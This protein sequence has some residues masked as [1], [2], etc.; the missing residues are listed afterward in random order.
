MNICFERRAERPDS[1]GRCVIRLVATFE[2]QRLRLATK[3]KCLASEWNERTGWFRKSFTDID[4][5]TTRLKDLRDRV[6]TAY[7]DL[8]TKHGAVTVAQLK[9]A[10][11]VEAGA[12]APGLVELL[13]EHRAGLPGRGFR[14]NTV[15]GYKTTRNAVAEWV[16]T[17]PSGMTVPEYNA[18]AHDA[19]IGW[20]R[21]E[22]GHGQNTIAG[23]VKHL[24]PF[25]TW[26][27]ETRAQELAVDPSKLVVEWEDVEKCWLTADELAAVAKA[28]LPSNLALVRD[29]FVFC[30]YTGLRYSDLSDL[31]PGNLADWKGG[32]VLRLT[33]T[34]TRTGVSI[35][36]TKPALALLNNYDGTRAR[37][38][39]VMANAVMNRYLKRI[40]RLAGLE[41]PVELVEIVD[42]RVF[43]R[44]VPK[45]ELVTM[46][47][48]RHTFATQSLMRGM[49]VEVL[50]KV[51]GHANIKTT[52]IYAK[53]VEDFQH[54]TMQRIW[55]G[56]GATMESAGA[57]ESQICAVEPS[58][59]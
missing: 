12:P 32:K 45:W 19:L 49:P 41:Q 55:E 21:E 10:L 56:Q 44:A 33:Q 52:L 1:A 31:H 34:K 43:K 3:E 23:M 22:K 58:A 42:G 24:K 26:A 15:K 25:L 29:A 46:H 20:L 8:R 51:L 57:L 47:T 13:D 11:S 38:M 18:A 17:L 14:A 30:C 59:A 2:N 4:N 53:I 35:Y 28:M 48:A 16:A 6:E 5:A 50:Q 40:A 27:R 39:P 37:L 54:F 36:L 7:S 9:A